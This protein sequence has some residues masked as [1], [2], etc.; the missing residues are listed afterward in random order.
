VSTRET[1]QRREK[2]RERVSGA[3]AIKDDPLRLIIIIV[4][5]VPLSVFSTW[6]NV[7]AQRQREEVY[8]VRLT[9]EFK[10]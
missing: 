4:I 6:L 8:V 1:E 2:E 9:G 5:V 7:E 3:G 10:R